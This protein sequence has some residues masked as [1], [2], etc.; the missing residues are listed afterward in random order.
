M[1]VTLGDDQFEVKHRVDDFIESGAPHPDLR[2]WFKDVRQ[3]DYDLDK[4]YEDR[5]E[6]ESFMVDKLRNELL[7]WRLVSLIIFLVFISKLFG[8]W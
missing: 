4:L 5:M 1:S 7:I 6:Y 3:I 8:I 2:R